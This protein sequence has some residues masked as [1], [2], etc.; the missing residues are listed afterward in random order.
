MSAARP[1]TRPAAGRPA[2]PPAALQAT[3]NDDDRRQRAKQYWPIR[4]ASNNKCVPEIVCL[5]CQA[6]SQTSYQPDAHVT[7]GNNQISTSIALRTCARC[8]SVDR[9]RAIDRS[10]QRE[11]RVRSRNPP[12]RRPTASRPQES[13]RCGAWRKSCTIRS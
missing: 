6:F 1:P 7:D 5:Y 8:S 12:T 9:Y 10:G 4:R 11:R 3:T 2:R 13:R